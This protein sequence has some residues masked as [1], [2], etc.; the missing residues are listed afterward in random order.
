MYTLQELKS[1]P[2]ID[3]DN[4]IKTMHDEFY[5]LDYIRYIRFN[6]NHCKTINK[7]YVFSTIGQQ[8]FIIN[9]NFAFFNDKISNYEFIILINNLSYLQVSYITQYIGPNIIFVDNKY[10][11]NEDMAID[12]A[13]SYEEDYILESTYID[14]ISVSKLAKYLNITEPICLN[15]LNKILEYTNSIMQLLNI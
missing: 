5:Q 9:N 4:V 10:H 8:H 13:Q 1:M 11:N 15:Y 14:D 12:L 7:Y 2:K 6:F 3:N